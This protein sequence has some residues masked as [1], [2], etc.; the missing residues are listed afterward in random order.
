[1]NHPSREELLATIRHIQA[2]INAIIATLAD[3]QDN[4]SEVSLI[5]DQLRTAIRES[6]ES[7]RSIAARS[8]VDNVALSRFVSGKKT[9]NGDSIDRIASALGLTLTRKRIEP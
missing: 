2:Q 1:M 3:D 9:L 5:T 8:H 4:L 7:M 6:G